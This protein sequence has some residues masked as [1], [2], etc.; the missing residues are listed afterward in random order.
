MDFIK[1]QREQQATHWWVGT[2]DP[3]QKSPAL[4]SSSLRGFFRDSIWKPA[5]DETASCCFPIIQEAEKALKKD[6]KANP[7]TVLNHCVTEDHIRTMLQGRT[8]AQ[9]GDEYQYMLEKALEALK[10]SI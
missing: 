9:L 7:L 4:V 8:D 5:P 2:V 1:S 10:G 6:K 3:R